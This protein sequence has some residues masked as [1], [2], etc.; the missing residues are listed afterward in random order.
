MRLET[1]ISI[2]PDDRKIL[3]PMFAINTTPLSSSIIEKTVTAPYI[4]LLV[5]GLPAESQSNAVEYL[6]QGLATLAT[7]NT[8]LPPV[9]VQAPQSKSGDTNLDYAFIEL[10]IEKDPEQ[11]VA[12]LQLWYAS[13]SEKNLPVC[14]A[15]MSKRDDL[16]VLSY[17]VGVR[18]DDT[19]TRFRDALANQNII[20]QSV[21]WSGRTSKR[22]NITLRSQIDPENLPSVQFVK[23]PK[24]RDRTP[25]TIVPSPPRHVQSHHPFEIVI[26]GGQHVETLFPKLRAI[27]LHRYTKKG[28]ERQEIDPENPSSRTHIQW[29]RF[30]LHAR[31]IILMMDSWAATK[32]ALADIWDTNETGL[33]HYIASQNIDILSGFTLMAKQIHNYN[34]SPF[35][36]NSSLKSNKDSSRLITETGASMK[37]E[38]EQLHSSISQIKSAQDAHRLENQT[39]RHEWEIEKVR[40]ENINYNLAQAV[41]HNTLRLENMSMMREHYARIMELRLSHINAPKKQHADIDNAL[42]ESTKELDTMKSFELT[43]DAERPTLLIEGPVRP[44][45]RSTPPSYTNETTR[46][47]KRLRTGDGPTLPATAPEPSEIPGI[48]EDSTVT[49]EEMDASYTSIDAR[50]TA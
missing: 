35:F 22:L 18:N 19:D 32:G 5:R 10:G 42:T 47:S 49:N 39:L 21:A 24:A 25:I 4:A 13:L 12:A 7:E 29:I 8:A 31:V 15:S 41:T 38:L 14:W 44:D 17:D 40:Q 28:S 26:N 34:N 43:L 37:R 16:R 33:P 46:K 48:N 6:Q 11:D 3:E 30:D 1:R 36:D 45:K 2:E 50:G 23:D 9:T 20:A 27:L